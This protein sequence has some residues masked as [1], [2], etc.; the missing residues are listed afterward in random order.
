MR[1]ANA[2]WKGRKAWEFDNGAVKLTVT[3]GG[4]H[5]ASICHESAP[6]VNPLWDPVW[7]PVEPWEWRP[8]RHRATHGTKLL[9][10]ICGHNLCLGWFGDASPEEQRLGLGCH[11][12]APVARWRLLSKRASRRT[13]AMT[14]GCELPAAGMGITRR[15]MTSPGSAVVRVRETVTNRLR[16]DVPY[17]MCEHVTF[18]PPFLEKGVTVFDMPATRGH[19]FPVSFE[20]HPRLKT[21]AAFKWPEAPGAKGGTVD[22]RTIHRRNRVSSDFSTQL[23]DPSKPDAW[24][25]AVNPKCGLMLA[26]CWRRDDFPWVGNWEENFG[27]DTPPWAGKSLTRGMEFANTPFPRGLKSAVALGAFHGLPTFRWLPALGRAEFEYAIVCM[28]VGADVRGVADMRAAG[29]GLEIDFL[30]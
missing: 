3:R 5:I 17:T 19:T 24:F 2:T 9:A 11:G 27:R 30:A 16:R 1:I 14:V 4:G 18:G 20:Q 28:P 21:D 26:Y 25:S 8:V 13:L 12:E 29:S 10:A 15:F 23:M 7:R 6:G 22:L